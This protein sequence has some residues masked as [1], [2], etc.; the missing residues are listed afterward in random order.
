MKKTEVPR[1]VKY[2]DGILLPDYRLP[3]EAEWEYAALGL[4]GNAND[5]RI[6]ERNTYPWQ[7]KH[8]RNPDR[9][10]M[11][12]FMANFKRG[13][14]D[15][16]GVAGSLND[17]A[18]IYRSCWFILA[19]RLRKFITWPAM[20]ANGFRMFTDRFRLKMFPITA[21]SGEIFL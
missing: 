17:G 11:G 8:V 1:R 3:T 14:G 9:K 4:I 19:K 16:M 12:S 6:I 18:D 2:E 20:L 7:G 10:Y 13:D 5:E 15:Y 21:L